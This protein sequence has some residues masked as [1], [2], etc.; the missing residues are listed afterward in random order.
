MTRFCLKADRRSVNNRS[1]NLYR[2]PAHLISHA[3]SHSPINSVGIQASN[4]NTSASYF[5]NLVISMSTTHSLGNAATAAEATPPS[6]RLDDLP[7]ELVEKIARRLKNDVPHWQKKDLCSLRLTCKNLHS[8]TSWLF[9]RMY[10]DTVSVAFTSRS[11]QRLH[12]IAHDESPLRMPLSRDTTLLRI[13]A[14]R[15]LWGDRVQGLLIP[16][17][18]PRRALESEA[19]IQAIE[20]ACRKGVQESGPTG[21]FNTRIQDIVKL[22][23]TAALDQMMLEFTGRG[24]KILAEA[25]AAFEKLE[26]LL[27]WWD[28]EAWGEEDWREIAGIDRQSFM[29]L[30]SDVSGKTNLAVVTNKVLAAIAQATNSTPPK[31]I[32]AVQTHIL[33]GWRAWR[34]NCRRACHYVLPRFAPQTRRQIARSRHT[35]L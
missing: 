7:T 9:G 8:K 21:P 11:L 28:V 33:L 26:H 15:L 1:V 5:I 24:V 17:D 2:E 14:H 29:T 10:F 12:D 6:P 23:K 20:L 16:Y 18:D 4:I 19:T 27:V 22:Y 35:Q 3:R 32:Q 31:Q 25:M 13:S 30:E 34:S